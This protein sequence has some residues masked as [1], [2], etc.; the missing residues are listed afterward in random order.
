MV[1]PAESMVHLGNHPEVGLCLG[2]AH[3]VHKQASGIEDHA[4]TGL[5]ARA[6]DGF[7]TLRRAVV[8]RGWHRHRLFGGPLR[9]LGRYLP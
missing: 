6:R 4:K 9:W 7:R 8:D 5:T 2:C 1:G 3:F